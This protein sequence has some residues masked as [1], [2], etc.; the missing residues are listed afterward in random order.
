MSLR[1]RAIGFPAVGDEEG[2]KRLLWEVARSGERRGNSVHTTP[3]HGCD[4][5][6]DV[7]SDLR[8]RSLAVALDGQRQPLLVERCEEQDG[9][10]LVDGFACLDGHP[11]TPIRC[12][13]QGKCPELEPRAIY[14]VEYAGF[15]ESI[16]AGNGRYGARVEDDFLTIEGVLLR[17]GRRRNALTGAGVHLATLWIPG[18]LI[19]VCCANEEMPEPGTDVCA[20]AEL[21]ITVFQRL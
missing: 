18:A 4:L 1:L 16:E 7:D 11:I 14:A 3:F 9:C 15:C 20:K 6:L 5:L 17:S 2:A 21:Y 13:A 10:L 12:H 8:A 19:P